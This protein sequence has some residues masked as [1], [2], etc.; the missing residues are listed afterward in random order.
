MKIVIAYPPLDSGKGVACLGQ[1]RQFQWDNTPWL[2]YPMVPSS[3]A[4]LLKSRGYD[5]AWLDGIAEGWSYAEFINHLNEEN[6]D[7]ILIETKTPVVKNHWTIINQLKADYPKLKTVLVGDH[8]TALPEESMNNSKVDYILT[9]GDFDFLLLNLCRHLTNSEPLEAGIWSREQTADGQWQIVN[10]GHFKLNHDLDSLP[11][12]DRDLTHW[13]LYAYK[14][15]NYRRKPGTYTMFGRDCWWGRCSFCSWTTL[16]PGQEHRTRSVKSAL[17]EIGEI[18]DRYPVREVMDDSGTFPVGDWLRDFCRGMIERGYNKKIR[19]NGNMRFNAGLTEAD[20]LLMGKAGFR[21]L[22]YGL[23]SANQSTLDRINKNMKIEQI[24]PVLTWAKKAGL[25]PHITVMV[26]YPWESEVEANK[27]LNLARDL[28]RKGLVDTMQAT[29]MIPYPGT[30]L[31]AECDRNDWLRTK[32]WPRYDMREPIMKSPVTDERLT[33]L[34]RSL[35]S[36][37]LSPQFI[38]RK[39]AEALRSPEDFRYYCSLGVKLISKL[40]DFGLKI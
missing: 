22:L 15:T 28:F 16:F 18:I 37:F 38:L 20:Y 9:G 39:L 10:T 21:F 1:N 24:E 40:K 19:L 3:A 26:G 12:I 2:A 17:D 11:F 31:F 29:V 34:T 32:E 13:E 33:A 7:L 23:E 27:T 35:Y 14:N 4:T 25:A 30:P 5:V 8:V 36:S 6:P